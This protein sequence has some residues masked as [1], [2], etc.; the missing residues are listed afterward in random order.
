MTEGVELPNQVVI[1]TLGEK[2]AYKY[3][4]ILE[5]NTIKQVKMKEKRIY[6][7]PQ[8]YSRQNSRVRTLSKG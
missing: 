3:L 8:N 4:G 2:E 7:E 6:Q 5:A 1:R